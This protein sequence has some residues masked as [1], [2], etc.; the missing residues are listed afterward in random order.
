MGLVKVW[1]NL[2]CVCGIGLFSYFTYVH[3]RK[4]LTG[5][6]I[7]ERRSVCKRKAETVQSDTVG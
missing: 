7:V 6:Y 3:F 5:R 2:L 4:F 1:Q